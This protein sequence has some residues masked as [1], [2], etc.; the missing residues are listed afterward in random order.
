M[1]RK[2]SQL[3]LRLTP[4]LGDKLDEW[5]REQPDIPSRSEAVR[6]LL[7]IALA[8]VRG[9]SSRFLAPHHSR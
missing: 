6:Q 7:E 4:D 2:P 5:R 1:E 9:Q 8:M 3:T